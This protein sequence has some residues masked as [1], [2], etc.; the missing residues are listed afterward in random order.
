MNVVVRILLIAAIVVLGYLLV[1]SI[2]NPIRFNQEKDR[3]E[4]AI[5]ERLID[6]R[7]AQVAFK[8][9]YGRYT[10]SFD[11]LINFV[12]TD[13]FPLIYKEGA[14]TDEWIEEWGAR[15]ERE[16]LRRGLIVRDTSYTTVLDSIFRPQFPVDSLRYVPYLGDT[17]F[18]M[19]AANVETASGVSVEVFEASVLNDVFLKGLD[20]QLIV[21]YNVLREKI[22]GFP[23]MRVGNVKEP[24]NNAGN[25]EN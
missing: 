19:E 21:N 14:I 3:R 7:T 5:K 11:T 10:G 16:A 12:K 4:E 18:K 2:L 9:K 15:A 23:G 24:N 17:E 22:T 1:D 25:W 8:S 6:I 13:S 20:E